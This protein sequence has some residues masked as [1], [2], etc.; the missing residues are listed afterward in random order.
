M[1]EFINRQRN[2][3]PPLFEKRVGV[4]ILTP[5]FF[6]EITIVR[7]NKDLDIGLL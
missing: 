1:M 2:P 5:V 4:T 7:V 3:P 6:V